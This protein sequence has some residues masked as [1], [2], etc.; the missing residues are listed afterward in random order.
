MGPLCFTV[1]EKMF[2]RL[3]LL[4]KELGKNV[5]WPIKNGQQ[6]TPFTCPF[7]DSTLTFTADDAGGLGTYIA[8]VDAS[9]TQHYYHSSHFILST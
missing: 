8:R 3:P 2:C 9:V 1:K 6:L 5:L 7:G 4:I